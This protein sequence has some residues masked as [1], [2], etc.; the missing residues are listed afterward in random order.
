MILINNKNNNIQGVF[1]ELLV[2]AKNS[3]KFKARKCN[4]SQEW[5]V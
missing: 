4:Q 1:L 5:I 2:S 3:N